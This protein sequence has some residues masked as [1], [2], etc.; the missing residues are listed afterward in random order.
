MLSFDLKRNIWKMKKHIPPIDFAEYLRKSD[1]SENS[2]V[3]YGR[4]LRNGLHERYYYNG[5]SRWD[6]QYL[7]KSTSHWLL[8]L[9]MKV[10][11]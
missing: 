8:L 11:L 6:V 7:E 2:E 1:I 10:K 5:K 3:Y 4:Y 9:E